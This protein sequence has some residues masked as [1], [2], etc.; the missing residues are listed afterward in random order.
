MAD[1][2]NLSN[3]LGDVADAIRTKKGTTE[4]IPAA[5]FD[6]E[7]ASIE[8]GSDIS[9]A[10]ATANDI[11][12]GTTAYIADGK[13]EGNIQKEEEIIGTMI[14]S[15]EILDTSDKYGFGPSSISTYCNR[16]NL[17]VVGV[18]SYP[19]VASL[20]DDFVYSQELILYS[21]S[22]FGKTDNSDGT[23]SVTSMS[24][25]YFRGIDVN[26]KNKT[27]TVK[28]EGLYVPRVNEY[29]YFPFI[30]DATNQNRFYVLGRS[31][32]TNL[33]LYLVEGTSHTKLIDVNVGSETILKSTV[34]YWA[35]YYVPMDYNPSNT[36]LLIQI[37]NAAGSN[38]RDFGLFIYDIASNSIEYK[39]WSNDSTFSY[40][41]CPFTWYDDNT[42]LNGNKI[43]KLENDNIIDIGTINNMSNVVSPKYAKR[44][45]DTGLVVKV[46]NSS[47]VA[48]S[49]DFA[50]NYVIDE[51]IILSQS[52]NCHPYIY[53]GGISI[54]A[55]NSSGANSYS[56]LYKVELTGE[57]IITKLVR[58]GKSYIDT[59]KGTATSGDI[60]E[61]K[62]AYSNGNKLTGAMPNNGAIN[63]TPSTE[64]QSILAGY[65]SGGTVSGDANLLPENI[66]SGTSIF[67][68]DGTFEGGTQLP[69]GIFVQ[70]DVPTKTT[71][72]AIWLKQSQA[73]DTPFLDK[74][75]DEILNIV[76]YD[77]TTIGNIFNGLST[78][79]KNIINSYQYHTFT[80]Y[81]GVLTLRAYNDDA[82]I[83]KITSD[84]LGIIGYENTMMYQQWSSGESFNNP[85]INNGMNFSLESLYTDSPIYANSNKSS[86]WFAS[87]IKFVNRT[88]P[89]LNIVNGDTMTTVYMNRGTDFE[90][91]LDTS[92]AD[93][94]AGDILEGKTAFVNN[95]KITGTLTV[96]MSQEEYNTALSTA[97]NILGEEVTE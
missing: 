7:I 9:D 83:Y 36:K 21:D 23:I 48:Q 2:S 32:N 60:L 78:E 57:K 40:E 42:L 70:S 22:Y 96:P 43:Q 85:A 88:E 18:D 10:T 66:K 84:M 46:L 50:N 27:C 16:H 14:G 90:K 6:A 54:V 5:N 34:G 38:Y 77:T 33:A 75:P 45:N 74:L 72:E 52:T 31:S 68:V 11:L 55:A 24:K 76:V 97:N 39:I 51:K 63:I 41:R 28:H 61:G 94:T 47:I 26:L 49:I 92:N 35:P 80:I 81:N 29:D 8:T 59:S 58:E 44:Y 3:F 73:D 56:S 25:G 64:A 19:K 20:D 17:A 87:N 37:R 13:V 15:S 4:T 67:G 62:I 91:I 86:V 71:N 79:R 12:A 30:P 93:A 65:T 95:T 53:D 89:G 82:F 69:D 1:T